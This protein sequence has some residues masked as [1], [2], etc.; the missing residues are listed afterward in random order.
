MLSL[1]PHRFFKE[2]NNPQKLAI[3]FTSEDN[4]KL[5][6]NVVDADGKEEVYILDTGN[7]TYDWD[8]E[9]PQLR[10]NGWKR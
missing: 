7:R 5:I 8:F 3:L 9:G 4:C 1:T 6:V 2:F 10:I